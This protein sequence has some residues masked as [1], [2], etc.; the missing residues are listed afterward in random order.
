MKYIVYILFLFSVEVYSQNIPI[1]NKFTD[2]EPRLHFEN[3]TLYIVNFW[4]TWC[5]PC[6]MELPYF[7]KIHREFANQKV[8]VLLISLDFPD[9]IETQL[10]PFLIR[11]QITAEVLV[12]NDGNENEWINKVSPTW[13]GAVPATLIFKGNKREFYEKEFNEAELSALIAKFLP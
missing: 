7:E 13:S 11:K 2:L 12:L 3:D 1:C 9:K 6:V 8:K 10:K 4:A 5:K